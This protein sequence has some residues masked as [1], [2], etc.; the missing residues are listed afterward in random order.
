M[1]KNIRNNLLEN[2]YDLNGNEISFDDIIKVYNIDK[3]NKSRSLGKLTPVHLKPNSFQKM[4][5]KLATQVLSQ[6]V[7]A[8]MET[9]IA[10]GELKSD[11]AKN[12]V[13]FVRNVNDLF[14]SLNSKCKFNK[15][16]FKCAITKN[17]DSLVHKTLNKGNEIFKQLKKVTI[18]KKNVKKLTIPPCFEG[19]Q[20]SINAVLQLAAEEFS[21]G[22]EVKF[23]MTNRLNQDV[24]ENLFGIYRMRGGCNR[25]PTSKNLR[26]MFRSNFTK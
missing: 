10:S 11:T 6:S 20:Q 21:Q 9:A 4:K 7:A 24:I 2:N 16:P 1:I 5:V 22:T 8:A 15:N 25:N 13:D 23:L 3:N 12:T 26:S 19:M 14:D 18:S 17:K